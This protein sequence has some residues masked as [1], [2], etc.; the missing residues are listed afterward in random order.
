[1]KIFGIWICACVSFGGYLCENRWEKFCQENE[2]FSWPVLEEGCLLK[3]A[4]CGI[5]PVTEE[6]AG[7]WCVHSLTAP[8]HDGVG[9]SQNNYLIIACG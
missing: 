5:V 6:L 2:C 9:R 7:C 8:H 1:M 3:S 4:L